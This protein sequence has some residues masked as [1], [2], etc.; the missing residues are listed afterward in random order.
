MGDAMM[1]LILLSLLILFGHHPSCGIWGQD[2][3]GIKK[4]THVEHRMTPITPISISST[5]RVGFRIL[6]I[7]FYHF[8]SNSTKIHST[9]GTHCLL[10]PSQ[11]HTSKPTPRASRTFALQA[12]VFGRYLA[13]H[14]RFWSFEGFKLVQGGI[15]TLTHIT[16]SSHLSKWAQRVQG[17]SAE[18]S[19]EEDKQIAL[20][21]ERPDWD[22]KWQDRLVEFWS[23]MF[24][25]S[26]HFD[27]TVLAA[28]QYG[29]IG[30]IALVAK[31]DT[32]HAD[33]PV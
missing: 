1:W 2:V 15:H 13:Q 9:H 33:S 24:W 3:L 12:K 14:N 19:I 26:K 16:P 22:G 23:A 17:P 25:V 31:S 5:D 30:M 32:M 21:T 11:T 18:D 20:P 4:V 6:F 8:L 10:W 7:S 27:H 29:Y 28:K